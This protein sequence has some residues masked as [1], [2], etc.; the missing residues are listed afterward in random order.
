NFGR[1]LRQ[2]E[3]SD[4]NARV[5]NPPDALAYLG[6]RPPLINFV[7]DRVL[8]TITRCHA[9]YSLVATATS[10][11]PRHGNKPSIRRQIQTV[12]SKILSITLLMRLRCRTL[13]YSHHAGVEIL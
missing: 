7:A 13:P 12:L 8:K 11:S 6:K 9:I 4:L 3:R 2:C 5:P 10:D 1:P